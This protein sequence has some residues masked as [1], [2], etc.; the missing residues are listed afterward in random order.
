M[1]A[2]FYQKGLQIPLGYTTKLTRARPNHAMYACVLTCMY[3]HPLYIVTVLIVTIKTG[4]TPTYFE[5]YM[6]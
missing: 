5:V 6:T 4:I 1:G 3:L 2:A